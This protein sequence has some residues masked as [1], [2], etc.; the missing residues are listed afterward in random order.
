MFQEAISDSENNA[1]GTGCNVNGCSNNKC[2]AKKYLVCPY[3][4]GKF[5]M[6]LYRGQGVLGWIFK[7]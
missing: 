5:G 4:S 1:S 7:Q 2:F 6:L 3:E